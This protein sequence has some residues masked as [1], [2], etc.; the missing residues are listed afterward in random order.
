M[1]AIE[2]AERVGVTVS[3]VTAKGEFSETVWVRNFEGYGVS[4]TS[5]DENIAKL[6]LYKNLSSEP[7]Y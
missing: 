6:I 1:K 2:N 5:I 7:L 3:I 4:P